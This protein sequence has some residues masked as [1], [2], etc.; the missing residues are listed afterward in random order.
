MKYKKDKVYFVGNTNSGKSTLINK[1]LKNY[2]NCI[3]DIT[4]SLYPS[5]TLSDILIKV[6]DE[7][8][9][10]DTPGIVDKGNLINNI[11][12][13][14]IKNITPKKEIKP[15]TYQVKGKGS[16]IIGKYLRLDYETEVDNSFTIYIANNI[17]ITRIGI[18]NNKFMDMNKRVFNLN[19]NKDIVVEGLCF[20][21]FVKKCNVSIYMDNNIKVY[22]RDNFI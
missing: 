20:I 2:S 3:S 8:E 19:D 4:T 1:L 18:K 10:I 7:L 13:K 22:E 12:L 16:L 21:K 6:N 9:I 15:R 5:T 14:E 11:S 17:N